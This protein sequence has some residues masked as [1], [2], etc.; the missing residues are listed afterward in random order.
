[1]DENYRGVGTRRIGTRRYGTRQ[2]DTRQNG[3][4][5]KNS[6]QRLSGQ[7]V[8]DQKYA[9]NILFTKNRNSISKI[10]L[11]YKSMYKLILM[12]LVKI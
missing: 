10:I 11:K 6:V 2:V 9:I 5:P 8:Y 3:N 4:K 1:M 12:N 7:R